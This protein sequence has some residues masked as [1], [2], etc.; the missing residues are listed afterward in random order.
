MQK[1][2][3]S[4]LLKPFATTFYYFLIRR[5]KEKVLVQK[6]S[7]YVLLNMQHASNSCEKGLFVISL[8]D[9]LYDELEVEDKV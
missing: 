3:L 6:I 9:F 1:A 2:D 7:I 8:P 4:H 5:A